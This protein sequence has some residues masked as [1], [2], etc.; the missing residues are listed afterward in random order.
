LVSALKANRTLRRFFSCMGV[1]LIATAISASGMTVLAETSG[2]ANSGYW[3]QTNV[4]LVHN[5]TSTSSDGSKT[6]VFSLSA[7]SAH[8]KN[9]TASDGLMISENYSWEAFPTTLIPGKKMSY[10]ATATTASKPK[11]GFTESGMSMFFD[12]SGLEAGTVTNN[13]I[14]LGDEATPPDGKTSGEV[15]IPGKGYAT[16]STYGTFSI[17]VDIG[18]FVQVGQVEYIYTWVQGTPPVVSSAAGTSATGNNKKSG[19]AENIFTTSLPGTGGLGNVP[20]PANAAQAAAGILIPGLAA[21]L[22]GTLGT[23]FGGGNISGTETAGGG[24]SSPE[25]PTL[26]GNIDGSNSTPADGEFITLRG[27]DGNDYSYAYNANSGKWVDPEKGWELNPDNFDDWQKQLGKDQIVAADQ[28]MKL[29]NRDTDFDRQADAL[30]QEGKDR[31]AKLGALIK[32]RNDIT[33]LTQ[34]FSDAE[35]AKV[36]LKLDGMIDSLIHG[37]QSVAQISAEGAKVTAVLDDRNTGKT[38]DGSTLKSAYDAATNTGV[39]GGMVADKLTDAYDFAKEKATD[40]ATGRTWTGMGVRAVVAIATEGIS[41]LVFTPLDLARAAQEGVAEDESTGRI[42]AKVLGNYA[43]GKVGAK[44]LSSGM[45]YLG[46]SFKPGIQIGGFKWGSLADDTAASTVNSLTRGVKP[47]ARPGVGAKKQSTYVAPLTTESTTGYITTRNAPSIAGMTDDSIKAIQYVADDMG[48][49]PQIRPTTPYANALLESGDAVPKWDEIKSKSLG[50]PDELLGGETS[51]DELL[52]GPKGKPGIVAYFKPEMPTDDFVSKLSPK[53]QENLT[54]RF[55]TRME[56]FEGHAADMERL[57]SEGKIRVKDGIIYDRRG[58]T[59]E[60]DPGKLITGDNDIHDFTNF[61]G[62][63]L[64]EY[65]KE[66]AWKRLKSITPSNVLHGNVT[67]WNESI[68]GFD[69]KAK[70]KMINDAR[71]KSVGV[72]TFNPHGAITHSFEDLP[73]LKV[74]D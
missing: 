70:I 23:L 67:S 52:G 5:G 2:G 74:P 61:D 25:S 27:K 43:M 1:I 53:A 34:G 54:K 71:N 11:E 73:L 59:S 68:H 62:S 30:V 7:A 3:K 60:D 13:M 37:N 42:V 46:Y 14:R 63:P 58:C 69:L 4:K 9:L 56:D 39:I 28:N 66:I 50:G 16:S 18:G 48:I 51:F 35:R 64:P 10:S 8:L 17:Y 41:E 40:V 55:T 12:Q 32:A 26:S 22:L 33:S 38:A 20:G 29:A 47:V 15:N 19:I 24:E 31:A 44:Y 57:T 6:T 21:L 49:R 45:N 72:N 36:N 65:V